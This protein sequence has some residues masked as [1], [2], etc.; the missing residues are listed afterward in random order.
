MKYDF[1]M[2]IDES[3]SVGKI[4]SHIKEQSSV[5][6]FGPGNGRMTN[7]LIEAKK[8]DVSIV[9]LDKELYD[10]VITFSN[11]GFYGNIEE[12]KWTDYYKGKKYDYIL[13]ADVLEHLMDPVKTLEIVKEF[14]KEDGEIL[15]TF[16]NIAHN[17]VLINLF[18]NKLDWTK[19]GLLDGT[20]KTF[21]TQSGFE[22]VFDSLGLYISKEDFTINVV[23]NNEIDAH[24]E[25]LPIEIVDAFRKR[26][27]AEVY[28]YFYALK[29]NPVKSPIRVLPEN[30]YYH[31]RVVLQYELEN[32]VEETTV[33]VNTFT[34]ENKNYPIEVP[35]GV[36]SLKIMPFPENIGGIMRFF[37]DINGE[38]SHNIQTSAVFEHNEKFVFT[39]MHPAYFILSGEDIAGKSLVLNFDFIYQGQYL[40]EINLMME[41][42]KEVEVEKQ[43][44]VDRYYDL[45]AG[46]QWEPTRRKS[47]KAFLQTPIEELNRV[48]ALNIDGTV[49]NEVTKTS[50][51][52]GWGVSNVD[53]MPLKFELEAN[54]APYFKVKRIHRSEINEG[55]GFPEYLDYGFEIEVADY[56]LE[57]F[58]N[59]V[60]STE[61]GESC[62]VIINRHIGLYFP[63]KPSSRVRRVLGAVK[64]KG[65]KGSVKWL[66]NRQVQKNSYEK[67]IVQHEVFDMEKIHSEIESFEYQPKI[68]IAVPVYNVEEKWLDAC[69][70]SL[71]N[72]FY[73]NWELCLADDASPKDYIRPLLEKYAASD[74]RI[75]LVFREKNG[76]IS[77]ATNSA[78]EIASGDYIGFMDNDDEL[79]PNALYEIVKALNKD[80]DIEFFYTD[81]DK[82]TLE[83]KRFDAFFKPNWNR[84]LILQHNYITHFVVVKD[85]LLS[86]I[87][88]LRTEY[89]GSQDY[90]FVLRATEEAKKIHH[91]KGILY[92]WRAIETSTALNP[93]SKTY[94]YVA[95]Q[96]AL[97]AALKRRNLKGN[98]KIA[99]FYGC[100]KIDFI[101]D[102][103]PKVSI[104]YVGDSK[105]LN[106]NLEILLSKTYY[107]NFEI[108]VPTSSKFTVSIKDARVRFVDGDVNTRVKQAEGEFILLLNEKLSPLSGA[109]LNELMNYA[110]LEESG[111]VCG[112]I[113]STDNL[114]SNIGVTYD[115]ENNKLIYPERNNPAQNLGYYYR[116]GLP[117]GIHA[118]TEDCMIFRKNDFE[119]VEGLSEE[120]GSQLMGL[121]FSLKVR[122]QLGKD[123]VYT[124]YAKLKESE[125]IDIHLVPEVLKELE[126]KWT[127]DGLIDPYGNPL[128]F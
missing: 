54:N 96:H 33:S 101:H 62:D 47:D 116:A 81:E 3:T 19:Y 94:A 23:G 104:V 26:P 92:H 11:D 109:W 88:G 66:L 52:K 57:Q 14:L 68:S 50:I 2:D 34:G 107:P 12:Y 98:I 112:K 55:F 78:L 102:T 27:F 58:F 71:K 44:I 126:K 72:Q 25:D 93:E 40:H 80:K 39:N 67:W 74:E 124:S 28:Q 113:S 83:E 97:E 24:Y 53:K 38:Q 85:A 73:T 37:V 20:H 10:Y 114:I 108:L 51:I 111:I 7:Y 118:S 122:Q 42:L 56:E 13:F 64:R 15:I 21:Y 127:K 89:N 4:A 49:R 76:H 22:K 41:R 128:S 117:R 6:E 59:F 125:P 45:V 9:E 30:S 91:I 90:D 87:G 36:K 95:G 110:Q 5:L 65:L 77:E 1:E 29:K 61:D 75:K 121:D 123:I 32:S 82:M 106:S 69:I 16:P 43:M 103:T 84:Q 60:I 119:Q 86:R 35:L 99:E 18:N 46:E 115:I 8:C 17:S 105:N 100:Y 120:F 63:A 31:R 79:A 70:S 48:M